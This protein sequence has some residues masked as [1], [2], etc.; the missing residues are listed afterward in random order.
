VL[1]VSDV[2]AGVFTMVNSR[3]L[4]V[5]RAMLTVTFTAAAA[6]IRFVG[7]VAVSVVPF[8]KLVARAA[9]FQLMTASVQID[10]RQRL[11]LP[12]STA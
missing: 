8:A 1:G 11:R 9:P 4:V 5:N 3:G 6:A 12:G 7:I 10:C 2:I